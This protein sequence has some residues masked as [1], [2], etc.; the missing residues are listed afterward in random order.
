MR[1]LIRRQFELNQ[2]PAQAW[3]RITDLADWP[4]WARHIRTIETE[5]PPEVGRSARLR[6]KNGTS[7]LVT[8]TRVEP[9]RSF[10]W[11]GT[12]LWLNLGYDHIVEP[13]EASSTITFVVEGGGPGIGSLGRVFAAVYRR[14]L[15]KAIAR[16]QTHVT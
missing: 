5:G 14:Q 6:L 12:F 10:Y 8:T 2:P 13:S 1:E 16:L 11:E 9:G 4:S 7:A 15:D 3:E